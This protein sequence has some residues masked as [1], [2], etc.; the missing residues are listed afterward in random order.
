MDSRRLRKSF[1]AL[2]QRLQR[3]G[4]G[5]ALAFLRERTAWMLF[6]D[7]TQ[8]LYPIPWAVVGAVATRLYMPER[9]T[10]DLDIVVRNEDAPEV[11]RRLTR[12]GF[13]YQ[14]EL[15][16]GG[17]SWL[18]GDGIPVDVLEMAQPWLAQALSETEHNRDAQGLPVLSLPYLVLMKVQAGR[19][20]DLADVTRMLGQA[21]DEA[22][23]A[24]RDLFAQYL[25]ADLE[26]LESIVLLGRME[27]QPPQAGLEQNDR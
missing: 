22:L 12:A 19:V 17:S 9:A 24:V 23:N 10:R 8:T 5:N 21:S 14:G 3:P 1:I 20:Q 25:P 27:M 16:I 2:A 13:A 6:P 18:S 11:R 4:S 15:S 26:D 7:L